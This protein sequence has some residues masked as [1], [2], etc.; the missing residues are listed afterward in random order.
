MIFKPGNTL[1][2]KYPNKFTPSHPTHNE[3]RWMEKFTRA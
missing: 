3:M 2:F 1:K